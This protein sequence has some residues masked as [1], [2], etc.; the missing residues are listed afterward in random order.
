VLADEAVKQFHLETAPA[1][2][3]HGLLALH[4]LHVDDR[5]AAVAYCLQQPECTYYYRGGFDPQLAEVSP[6]TLMLE[7]AI[8]H[9]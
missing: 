1:L 5:V 2:L 3:E 4:A 9:A 6:G 7:R 8:A